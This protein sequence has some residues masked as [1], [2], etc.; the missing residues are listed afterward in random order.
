MLLEYAHEH[1]IDRRDDRESRS[2]PGRPR[3]T[4][5]GARR[6]EDGKLTDQCGWVPHAPG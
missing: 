2:Q 4:E 5:R 6:P 3:H 1:R